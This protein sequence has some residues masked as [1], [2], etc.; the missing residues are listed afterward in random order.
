MRL[1]VST[2]STNASFFLYLTS[3]L[4]QLIAPVACD[5]IFDDSSCGKHYNEESAVYDRHVP[6]PREMHGY[7]QWW[8]M[9]SGYLFRYFVGIRNRW[10]LPHSSVCIRGNGASNNRTIDKLIYQHKIALHR[11]LVDFP[12]VRTRNGD[13]AV[14]KLED[15]GS[16]GV[17]SRKY[18]SSIQLMVEL[19]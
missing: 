7:F 1:T 16:I 11:L 19:G 6:L 18:Q 8:C 17:I 15:E 5:V 9:S 3:G 10:F 14:T 13:E 2:T 4:R 12:E